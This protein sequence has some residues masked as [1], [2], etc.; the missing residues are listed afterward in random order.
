MFSADPKS[1]TVKNVI[2][3]ALQWDCIKDEHHGWP[4]ELQSKLEKDVQKNGW[5]DDVTE[6]VERLLRLAG[7]RDPLSTIRKRQRRK[8]RTAV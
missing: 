2:Y 1:R 4:L 5:P 7:D 6:L 8:D 3:L